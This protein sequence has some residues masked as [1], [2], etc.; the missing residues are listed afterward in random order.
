MTGQR[1][2]LG[3]SDL[4][5][6]YRNG[7]RVGVWGL[8]KEG[9]AAVRKLHTLGIAPVLVDDSPNESGVL[10]TAD[11]GL[12][13]LKHAEVVIKTPGISP[14]G[15]AAAELRAAG[16][17]LVGGL[18]LWANEADLSRVVYVTG[19]KGKSTT[20][21]V[22]GHWLCGLG[23]K[24]LVGGNF[25]AAPYDPARGSDYD[26][27]VIEVSSYT[28]TDLVVT[29]PVTAVTSLHPDHL[30]WH[31]GVERYYVDKLS[32]TSQPG[33]DL[34]VANG[35]SELLRERAGLL[36]P[37]IAWVSETDEPGAT[38][39]A[40]LNLQGRHN[41]RNA[42]IARAVLRALA[43]AAGDEELSAQ[44]ADDE[45]IAA[46][47]AD[48]TPLPSRLTPVGTVGG[49]TFIDDSLSTNVLPTL[50]A[51]DS[52]PG[53]RVALIVG[54]QDRGIDYTAL[55]QGV[56]RR[57]EP[58]CVLTLPDSGPRITA[59]FAATATT[60]DAG[61]AGVA[62][63]ADLDEAVTRAFAWAKPDGIVLLSPAAPSFGHF[64]DYR[65]RGDHFAAAMR[66]LGR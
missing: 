60:A 18:S 33:A 38:W 26:Y 50:A 16:V 23:R 15:P 3:W 43:A 32:A 9:H 30:P 47:A 51:L 5:S 20:S 8:G 11:G 39:M 53:K 34:T 19:T 17:T 48:F 63:C 37:R 21:S 46:A 44:A 27:W 24:A 66:A 57:E 14:Y 4:R 6:A 10:P 42:L 35:D 29:P 31:G 7:T 40:P 25:G 55:A 65:D 45:R 41:R 28:A 59:A 22:I 49:V 62:D 54:G 64:R 2:K 1:T 36:G 52:F 61:F 13:A 58:T 56:R 12:D